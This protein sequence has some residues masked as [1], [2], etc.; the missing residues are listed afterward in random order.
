MLAHPP[1]PAWVVP[2]ADAF[3]ECF[4]VTDNMLGWAGRRNVGVLRVFLWLTIG[5]YSPI[6][7]RRGSETSWE[8]ARAESWAALSL[9]AGKPSPTVDDW[10]RLGIEPRPTGT[11]DREFAYGAWRALAWLLGVREDWPTYTSWHRAA[12]MPHEEEHLAVPPSERDT[13]VWRAAD[14]ASR[15]RAEKDALRHWQHIRERVDA[16]A[17]Q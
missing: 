2:D 16:T 8:M 5:E 13:E 15:D 1:P 12:S 17:G 7:E 14:R 3:E 9:A 6:T 11:D 10:R 4:R